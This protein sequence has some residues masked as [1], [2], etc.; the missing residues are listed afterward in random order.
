L[1]A[2]SHA[3]DD[4]RA[5]L[6]DRAGIAMSALCMAHCL[7][8]AIVVTALAS[9]GGV[10]FSHWIH[11]VGLVIAMLLGAVALGQGVWRHGYLAPFGVGCFGL[12]MMAGAL[13]LHGSSTEMELLAT[14]AGVMVLALGHD[15][16]ARARS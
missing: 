13:S 6:L 14:L 16:N 11:E 1:P 10:L 7:T 15:L 2:F 3:L 5:T 8:S 9:F 12:G 4:R